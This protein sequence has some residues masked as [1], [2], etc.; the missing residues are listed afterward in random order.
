MM[1]GRAVAVV[2]ASG[3]IGRSVSSAL[4]IRHVRTI[5]ITA[6]RLPSRAGRSETDWDEDL[7]RNLASQFEGAAAVIN[8]AGIAD[9]TSSDAHALTAANGTLAGLVGRAATSAGVPRLIQVSSAATQGRVAVLDA[10]EDTHPFSAYSRSKAIG[11]ELSLLY[12]PSTTVVYRPAGVHGTERTITQSIARLARSRVSCV[13]RPG[14]ANS[15]QALIENVADAIAFLAT[16][17]MTPPRVVNHPSEGISTSALLTL[18]GGREPALLP[19]TPARVIAC[20]GMLATHLS[21]S[22]GARARRLEM[23]WFG[24]SQ[25]PSWLSHA[26]WRPVLGLDAWR[27][28]GRALAGRES[29]YPPNTGGP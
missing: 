13:A 21:P 4:T 20:A 26:G 10:T 27:A 16:T 28:L 22:I 24:Q 9:A 8:A 1:D 14:D 5:P 17:D 19:A 18:L 25:A 2:G 15:P 6:P 3:F 29:P 11:E 7:T 12:G 23:L